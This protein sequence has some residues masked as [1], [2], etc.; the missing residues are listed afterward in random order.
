MAEVKSLE[1]K[2]AKLAWDFVHRELAQ[3][4]KKD[5]KD[6]KSALRKLPAMILT[7]GFGQT[8]AFHIS[9]GKDKSHYEIIKNIADALEKL[10]GIAEIKEPEKLIE[11]ITTSDHEIYVL[12]SNEAI[13]YATWLKRFA[14]AELEG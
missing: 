12:L 5:Q 6:F 2:R 9:K 8:V 14:E 13:K 10:T 7:S 1:Q 11:K 3:K 4:A